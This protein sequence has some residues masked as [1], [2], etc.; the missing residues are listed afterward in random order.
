MMYNMSRLG[1]R[2]SN[3]LGGGGGGV[4][5]I[6]CEVCITF[7]RY[8]ILHE[9]FASIRFNSKSTFKCETKRDKLY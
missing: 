9:A 5:L 7:K 2:F 1:H 3:E 8:Q 6:F 4:P